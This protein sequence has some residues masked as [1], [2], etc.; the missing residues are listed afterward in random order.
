MINDLIQIN[1][2]RTADSQMATD[3]VS[4]IHIRN[5]N[6]IFGFKHTLT[7]EIII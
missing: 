1:H 3:M 7:L 4:S 6:N 5:L 2:D